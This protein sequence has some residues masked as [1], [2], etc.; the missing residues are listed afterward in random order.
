MVVY[1][2]VSV[3][4]ADCIYSLLPH[5]P[6][7][8]LYSLNLL[9]FNLH[10]SDFHFCRSQI[11]ELEKCFNNCMLK[12]HWKIMSYYWDTKPVL[13]RFYGF[14]VHVL[15]SMFKTTF[16][17]LFAVWFVIDQSNRLTPTV[18]CDESENTVLA[19]EI[20]KL[21]KKAWCY[22]DDYVGLLITFSWGI[23]AHV[24]TIDC[25]LKKQF[26]CLKM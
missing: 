12:K 1:L 9:L 19:G 8:C 17:Y 20:E 24:C 7:S 18:Q 15:T 10:H 23:W 11:G 3:S 16:L 21:S 4:T 25:I 26:L 6:Q 14:G 13:Q 2:H 5:L 22:F